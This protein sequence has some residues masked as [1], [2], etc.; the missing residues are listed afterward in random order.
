MAPESVYI[1]WLPVPQVHYRSHRDTAV[2]SQ[3]AQAAEEVRLS[4]YIHLVSRHDLINMKQ[5]Q[6]THNNLLIAFERS[7]RHPRAFIVVKTMSSVDNS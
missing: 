5:I 1:L 7:Q 4:S 6:T 3:P 2:P